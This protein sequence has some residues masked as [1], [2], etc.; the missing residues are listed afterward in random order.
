MPPN[1]RLA[2]YI[3]LDLEEARLS[4]QYAAITP[5]LGH[6][7]PHA[8]ALL[9]LV[10]ILAAAVI[11]FLAREHRQ[12]PTV[13]PAEIARLETQGQSQSLTLEDGSRIEV[14]SSSALVLRDVRVD[15]VSLVLERGSVECEV[16]KN[17]KRHFVVIAADYEVRV[18]GTRFKVELTDRDGE[19]GLV[20][21]VS[22]GVVEIAKDGRATRQIAAGETF[23]AQLGEGHASRPEPPKETQPE[24]AVKSTPSESAGAKS[25]V[26]KSAPA[27]SAKQL[28]DRAMRARAAGRVAEARE[29]LQALRVRYPND[30]RA[31]LAAFEIARLELDTKGDP[32]NASKLL[33]DAIRSAPSGSPLKEDAEA[34]RIEALERAGDTK[35]CRAAKKAF[36]ASYPESIHRSRVLSA[37]PGP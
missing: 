15:E 30:P 35:A 36:L 7:R 25:V 8:R 16:T 3:T 23:S 29:A 6:R 27:E 37:C 5:R 1:N 28:F 26:A 19:R 14:A 10:P 21:G 17:P 33:D 4:R 34:R 2:Q 31:S 11:F 18:V 13:A 22:R 12:S 32:K 24:P 20:V 9:V